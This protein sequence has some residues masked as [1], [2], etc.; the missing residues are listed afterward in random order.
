[1]RNTLEVLFGNCKFTMNCVCHTKSAFESIVA[2]IFY[3]SDGKPVK[4]VSNNESFELTVK[5]PQRK[6]I[7]FVKTDKCLLSDEVKKCDCILVSDQIV[8]LVEIKNCNAG[9]RGKRR[10]DASMQLSS[11]IELLKLYN[12]DFNGYHTTALICFKTVEPRITQA[13][14][15]SARAIFKSKYGISLEEGNLITF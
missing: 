14:K 8:Y 12:F 10:K 7:D 13:S 11:T 3:V 4:I 1:M 9:G 6:L 15:N 2:E 5:N